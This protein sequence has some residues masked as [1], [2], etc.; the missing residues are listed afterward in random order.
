MYYKLYLCGLDDPWFCQ[1]R[2]DMFL[3]SKTSRAPNQPLLNGCHR[4]LPLGYSRGS[5][6]LTTHLC[7]MA[8]YTSTLATGLC[9]VDNL[10]F[11]H[12]QTEDSL[13]MQEISYANLFSD[14]TSHCC[15]S[16]L[17]TFPL[18]F[19]G[20]PLWV[21][22]TLPAAWWSLWRGWR[23]CGLVTVICKELKAKSK[24]GH[25]LT[26]ASPMLTAKQC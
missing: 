26:C 23:S 6:K 15:S 11:P 18:P 20:Q 19:W 13:T 8:G 3:S 25:T 1:Q 16:C 22:Q 24:W 4:L 21:L 9:S 5:I 14:Q 17:F 12:Y 10:T 7:L 2:Q